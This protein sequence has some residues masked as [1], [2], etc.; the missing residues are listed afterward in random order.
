MNQNFA[1]AEDVGH[2][3]GR[4]S[5]GRRA[6]PAS[7]AS[8]AQHNRLEFL[9]RDFC[10][11]RALK[12]GKADKRLIRRPHPLEECAELPKGGVA[13]AGLVQEFP[14]LREVRLVITPILSHFLSRTMR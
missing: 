3:G 10:I 2:N 4:K 1:T 6:C 8:K 13:R 11:Q 5:Q 9:K 12:D 7:V 14:H